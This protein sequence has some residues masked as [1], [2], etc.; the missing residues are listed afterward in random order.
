M[1]SLDKCIGR[2]HFNPITPALLNLVAQIYLNW[3]M[4]QNRTSKQEHLIAY[5]ELSF[6]A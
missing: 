2:A 1:F 5:A 3:S 6:E 4:C